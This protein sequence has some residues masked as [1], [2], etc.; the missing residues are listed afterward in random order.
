[1]TAARRLLAVGL[2]SLGVALWAGVP[3]SRAGRLGDPLF[4]V[5]LGCAGFGVVRLIAEAAAPNLP[6]RSERMYLPVTSRLWLDGLSAL[7]AVPWPQLLIVTAV[8]L[9]ALHP[10]QPWHTA[11]LAVVLIGYL[12]TLHLAESNSRLASFGPQLPLIIAGISLTAISVG[13]AALPSGPGGS[14]SG[15]LAVLAA[16]AAVVA[17]ALALPI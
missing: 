7:V 3:P 4:F 9:E 5:A 13:A 17:A 2:L 8:A 12:I 1:V 16:I 10:R 14:G 6:A 11:V 15:W